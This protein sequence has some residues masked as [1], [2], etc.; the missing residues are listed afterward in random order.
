MQFNRIEVAGYLASK[1]RVFPAPSGTLMATV[2]MGESYSYRNRDGKDEQQT[3]WYRL[4]FYGW[5]VEIVGAY[6]QGDNV[7]V[8]GSVHQR[9]YNGATVFEVV[10]R[11][12]HRIAPDEA[13]K[14]HETEEAEGATTDVWPA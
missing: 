6:E 2:R 5:L 7:F 11:R 9:E 4:V 10:V 3:N 1:P 14:Q 8:D 13:E 12:A